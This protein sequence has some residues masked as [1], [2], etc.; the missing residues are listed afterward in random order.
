MPLMRTTL[1][2]L[3]LVALLAG[4]GSSDSGSKSSSK[5][6]SSSSSSAA[7]AKPVA[8]KLVK[9]ANY[10][11]APASIEVKKGATVSFT[12]SDSTPHTATS[13]A[14][15]VF[16]SGDVTSGKPKKVT[17]TKA[18]TFAYYCVYHPYMAGTVKVD[19]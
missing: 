5:S 19:P 12:N 4:C 17:F 15:G 16:D 8:A 10:K 2:I 14:K 11:Y 3:C 18:G 1:P 9:I 7:K 6:S 13:K